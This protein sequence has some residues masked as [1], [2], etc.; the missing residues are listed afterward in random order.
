MQSHTRPAEI[1]PSSTRP[2]LPPNLSRPRGSNPPF[3]LRTDRNRS[4]KP[5]EAPSP[6]LEI[7]MMLRVP[8]SPA[9]A[10]ANQPAAAGSAARASVRVA[11]PRPFGTKCM[12]AAKGKEV[13]SGVV[14]QPFKELKGDLSLVPQKPDQSLT[15]HKYIDECEAAI[16]QQIKSVLCSLLPLFWNGGFSFLITC[17]DCGEYLGNL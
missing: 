17:L 6:F 4:P 11:A 16:N 13:L 2:G 12:A 10:S 8:S 3:V 5:R 7:E 1:P 14:F 9:A 15:R